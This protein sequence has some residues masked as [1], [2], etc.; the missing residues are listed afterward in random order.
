MA[1]EKYVVI[2]DMNSPVC[3]PTE[4]YEVLGIFNTEEEAEKCI[5]AESFDNDEE[6]MEEEYQG[7]NV[8]GD[9]EQ[10]FILPC[11]Q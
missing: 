10:T 2:R 4:C 8:W 1:N 3:T 5:L 6:Q 7:N 11:R 9:E